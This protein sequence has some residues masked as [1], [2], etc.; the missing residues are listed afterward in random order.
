MFDH[1]P[2]E[3]DR[4]EHRPRTPNNLMNEHNPETWDPDGPADR[5]SVNLDVSGT[6]GPD[7]LGQETVDVDGHRH[8]RDPDMDEDH[9]RRLALRG[10]FDDLDDDQPLPL[11]ES[12][13]RADPIE[14]VQGTY[15]K[16]VRLSDPCDDCLKSY[17]V[18]SV[19]TMAGISAVRC[20][21]CGAEIHE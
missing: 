17:G 10:E 1:G 12:D 3:D 5:G 2:D 19:H 11:I 4:G 8:D 13:M 9:A 18:R 6:V 21:T 14:G 20:L 15:S 16:V 7:H